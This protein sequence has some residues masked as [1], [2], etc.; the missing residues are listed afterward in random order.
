MGK[1]LLKRAIAQIKSYGYKVYGKPDSD[2]AFFTDGK[3]IGYF[4][5]TEIG[6]LNFSTVHRPNRY[7]GTGYRVASNIRSVDEI[8]PNLCRSCF[9]RIPDG[10]TNAS[11]TKWNSWDEFVGKYW[12]KSDRSLPEL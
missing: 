6:T 11:I 4:Q 2:Y 3:N 5:L 7:A 8:T 1:E 12:A 9:G 10:F